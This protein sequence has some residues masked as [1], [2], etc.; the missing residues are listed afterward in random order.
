MPWGIYTVSFPDRTVTHRCTPQLISPL[1]A[2]KATTASR[3]PVYPSLFA[4][5]HIL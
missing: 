2:L 4:R 3:S 5:L 1:R